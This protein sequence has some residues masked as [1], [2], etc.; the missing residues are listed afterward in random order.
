MVVIAF[1]ALCCLSCPNPHLNR[2]FGRDTSSPPPIVPPTLVHNVSIKVTFGISTPGTAG[3]TDTFNAVHDYVSGKTAAQLASEG[4]IQLGDYIDL[5][6]GLTVSG[7]TPSPTVTNDP[8]GG[9]GTLLR[10]IVVGINSFNAQGTYTYTGNGTDAHLVFQFQNLPF[11]HN[12]NSTE[13]NVGGYAL[14]E[15]RSYIMGAFLT[16]L[17]AAGVPNSLL[18]A[19]TRHVA[20]GGSSATAA[21]LIA[22]KLWLPTELE[23]FGVQVYS[24]GGWETTANQA[25]LEY[26][27]SN[28]VRI[29]YDT[30]T[31]PY[32]YWLASPSSW[33]TPNGF[34]YINSGGS[35]AGESG[36]GLL[37]PDAACVPAFCVK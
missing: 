3:V 20:N 10:L 29:K 37:L 21:D 34:C 24:I 25:R 35:E 7:G 12:M 27:S 13:T 9:H 15:M 5:E 11:T 23:M 1:S 2:I 32:A 18:W 19:P 28:S 17:N 16:G 6:G 14:S 4:I 8:L 36:A 22:D 30:P 31:H 26:Y 33:T